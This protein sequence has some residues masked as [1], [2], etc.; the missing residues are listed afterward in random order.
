ME[1]WQLS[2]SQEM[3]LKAQEAHTAK[4]GAK[5]GAPSFET[6]RWMEE[7]KAAGI[8]EQYTEAHYAHIRKRMAESGNPDLA[9]NFEG[10]IADSRLSPEQKISDGYRMLYEAHGQGTPQEYHAQTAAIRATQQA[11]S[12]DPAFNKLCKTN[13]RGVTYGCTS[14]GFQNCVSPPNSPPAPMSQTM[15]DEINR[16]LG[17]DVDFSQL[18]T[19]EQNRL[20]G[21]IPWGEGAGQ[22]R[23]GVTIA[24][25][26]DLGAGGEKPNA[27][28]LMEA[29][30]LKGAKTYPPP[31]PIEQLLVK[32]RPYFGLQ[33][34][35]AC[36]KLS[37]RPLVITQEEA[38]WLNRW[39]MQEH[40]KKA[41]EGL[42]ALANQELTV[43]NAG[44]PATEISGWPQGTPYPE[45][46]L[47]FSELT[48][49]AQTVI[50]SRRYQVGN[51]GSDLHQQMLRAL[52]YGNSA[53]AREKALA[54]LPSHK[55]RINKEFNYLGT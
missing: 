50:T 25:G 37:D 23:S 26:V 32:I 49:E 51:L 41:K 29:D 8:T 16:S 10:K 22:N 36:N 28:R 47:R 54:A 35:T 20:E 13:R 7:G 24:A 12:S 21:Y 52:M 40:A 45:K 53:L 11:I 15:V 2:K 30:I 34:R 55:A 48:S 4:L 38:D 6:A 3:A 27:A 31:F 19:W 9:E 42:D 1:P 39:K 44:H 43:R 17:T 18:A 33:R 5:I 46:P 14:A